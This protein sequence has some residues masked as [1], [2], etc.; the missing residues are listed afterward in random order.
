[1]TLP[2][3][4]RVVACQG[5]AVTGIEERELVA[6]AAG[7][8]LL[9]LRAVG[10]CGTDLFKLQTGTVSTGQVLGHELVGE[11]VALGAGVTGFEHGDRVAVPHHVP[12][13]HCPK[14]VRGSETLCETFRQNLLEPG[15]FADYVLVHARAVDHAARRLSPGLADLCAVWMEPAACVLRGIDRAGLYPRGTAVVQGCGSMGLLH[16]LVLKAVHPALEVLMV[17]PLHERRRLALALGADAS[18]GPDQA[19]ACIM[20][21]SEGLGADAV[22]DTVGGAALLRSALALSREGGSVILFAHAPDGQLADFDINLLFKNE[23]RIIGSYSGTPAEQQ[24]ILTLMEDGRL[25]PRPLVTHELDLAA[26]QDGVRLSREHRAL[27]VVFTSD[28]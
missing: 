15:G 6:P 17:D 12:C 26:F 7:Q 11:V 4:F 8:M 5:G 9:R 16:L 19:L 13:G 28:A 20:D 14:C 21:L 23:R 25:D 2:K 1:M 10:L 18:A 22:F 3:R 27:K 24:R